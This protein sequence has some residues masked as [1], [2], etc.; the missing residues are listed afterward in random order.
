MESTTWALTYLLS[1]GGVTLLIQMVKFGLKGW[2]ARVLAYVICIG[3]AVASFWIRGD[4][5]ELG[6]VW[7]DVPGSFGRLLVIA[8]PIFVS[9]Q[10]FYL[11]F[12][13]KLKNATKTGK[14]K[15]M[16]LLGGVSNVGMKIIKLIFRKRT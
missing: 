14:E 7:D 5:P 1:G 12:E 8:A 4:L 15:G 11:G 13:Q 9:A 6:W 3:A 16:N 10:A 2:K